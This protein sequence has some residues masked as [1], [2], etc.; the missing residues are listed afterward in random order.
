M[1]SL[2]RF[3]I[4]TV[5]ILGHFSRRVKIRVLSALT[6]LTPSIPAGYNRDETKRLVITETERIWQKATMTRSSSNMS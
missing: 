1:P 4:L 5:G 2:L 3:V 6:T